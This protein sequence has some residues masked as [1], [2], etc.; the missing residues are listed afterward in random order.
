MKES[1]M[2]ANDNLKL[3][4]ARYQAVN[5]H[6]FE[7]FQS[8]YGDS[9]VWHDPG[10]RRPIKGPR[11]VGQRLRTLTTAVPDLKW[12][13]DKLFG[14]GQH[15]CAQFTFT[16]TQKGDLTNSRG[17]IIA[18]SGKTIRIQ[19]VGV[20]TISRGKIVDSRIYMDLSSLLALGRLG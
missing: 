14:Q 20:Y 18:A 1:S 2:N 5:A 19:A 11:A 3:I 6:D 12:K 10:L 8:F 7:R 15:V 4:R 17:E 9:I 16:G 13:L